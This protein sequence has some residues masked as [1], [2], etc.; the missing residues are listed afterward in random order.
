MFPSPANPARPRLGTPALWNRVRKE[1]GIE[2]VRVHDL[3]H[4]VASQAVAKGV[5]LPTVARMLGHSDPKMTLRYAHVS[6]R[7]V[8]AAAERIGKV[9]ET[10]ME[11]GRAPPLRRPEPSPNDR[12]VMA[13]SQASGDGGLFKGDYILD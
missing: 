2:D 1:A 3:R 12:T 7:D 5:A 6:D 11:T 13:Q 8:E 4:T 10:A 9:I